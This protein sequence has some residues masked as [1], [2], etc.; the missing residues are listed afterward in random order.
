MDYSNG[1][2]RLGPSESYERF[3]ARARIRKA[4]RK[5]AKVSLDDLVDAF[6]GLKSDG[7]LSRMPESQTRETLVKTMQ[8][9]RAGTYSPK[10]TTKKLI[11][12]PNGGT[13]QLDKPTKVDRVVAKAILEQISPIVDKQFDSR[14]HGGR[15]NL[16]LPFTLA[17]AAKA[18]AAGKT[19]VV[20]ADIKDAFPAVPTEATLAC[21]EKLLGSTN[22]NL[23]LAK[24]SVRGHLGHKRVLGIGQGSPLS[25]LV[26]NCFMHEW[27]DSTVP[28]D[29]EVVYVRYLDNLYAFGNEASKPL[30]LMEAIKAGLARHG[31]TLNIDP[32]KDI[33][34]EILPILGYQ[35]EAHKG[36]IRLVGSKKA[37]AQLMT[38]L[39]KV[40]NKPNPQV[41]GKQ[42]VVSWLESQGLR[43]RWEI[44]DS[45]IV[46]QLMEDYGLDYKTSYMETLKVME[47]T[48]KDWIL[49]HTLDLPLVQYAKHVDSL[50]NF[51]PHPSENPLG[52]NLM[53]VLLT[54][55]PPID[56][57]GVKALFDAS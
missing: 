20:A 16:G 10:A 12:K 23:E 37:L 17:T 35:A 38:S 1:K 22:A 39:E 50:G 34:T 54:A 55:S 47:S 13:R 29:S 4:Q 21:L 3:K 32:V 18:I 5:S 43:D 7:K 11:R 33:K 45:I 51:D 41:T 30:Q 46:N 14:S 9:I 42:A 2:R 31:M 15:P 52:N 27:V 26:F 48:R 56:E 53:K 8:M 19:F 28:L 57:F 6:K 36:K 44:E 49:K 25:P 24:V 40:L